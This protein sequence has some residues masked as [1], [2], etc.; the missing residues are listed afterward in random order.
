[1]VSRLLSPKL[2]DRRS[3]RSIRRHR[4]SQTIFEQGRLGMLS[5]RKGRISS[6]RYSS[7][8]SLLASFQ[9][10]RPIIRVQTMPF[11]VSSAP[12]T[13][14]RI[15]NQ[16]IKHWRE[17]GI[18]IL[19]YLDD[20]LI[21]HSDKSQCQA[22]TLYVLDCLRKAGINVNFEKSSLTP[23]QKILHL[24]LIW[25]CKK[26]LI[27]LPESKIQDISKTARKILKAKQNCLTP[28]F[29]ARIVGKLTA[30]STAF[31][32]AHFKR[33]PLN[34]DLQTS[35]KENGM[36]WD[37]PA[38]LGSLSRKS[39]RFFSSPQLMRKFNG[40][41]LIISDPTW[42]ITTD[43]SPFGWGAT[44][45]HKPS[46]YS[47]STKGQFSPEEEINSSNWKETKALVLA[48]CAFKDLI[49]RDPGHL[50][51]RSDNTT[52]L[53]YLRKFG[54]V[55]PSLQAAIDPLLRFI[56]RHNL[57]V[58]SSHIPGR[59]NIHADRLSRSKRKEHDYSLSPAM[60]SFLDQIF[61]PHSLDLFASRI[62]NQ[63]YR[64]A[65]WFPDPQATYRDA[66]SLD[67]S[68]ENCFAFPPIPL[69]RKVI[70][71][72][73]NSPASLS[74][75]LV[76][77]HWPSATWWSALLRLSILDPIPVP[78]DQISQGTSPASARLAFKTNF[79]AFRLQSSKTS[80]DS[81]L[82]PTPL[83]Q[84]DR[85]LTK[86]SRSSSLIRTFQTMN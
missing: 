34:F 15:L 49:L 73:S 31:L 69:I 40:R 57:L 71:A 59:E 67:W 83:L 17:K 82:N 4:E 24:G 72:F 66:F 77:P 64:F 58:T 2:Y 84:V 53:S 9:S 38:I 28:R 21:H 23:K 56:I 85:R 81:S 29:I 22:D 35:L 20:M 18:Q 33:H 78:A 76:V 52:A 75:T 37:G 50:H 11:G 47:R 1:M 55:I 12:K 10:R 45:L 65:S 14:V 70:Q 48:V 7:E 86:N 68:Q 16:L 3:R 39:L 13:W 5:R 54:G 42:I 8:K 41:P 27:L 26:N 36:N 6:R 25:N 43:A 61:G 80:K 79:I 62:N 46:G 32:P 19:F 44:I 60:F 63:T 51:I 30:A 74:I